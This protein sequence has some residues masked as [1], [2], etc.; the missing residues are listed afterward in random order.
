MGFFGWVVRTIG[1][2]IEK[3][4]DVVGS[5]VISSLGIA[6]QDACAGRL[7]SEK[8]YDKKEANIYTTDR[9]NEVLVSFSEG[10]LQQTTVIE[11]NCIRLVDEYYDKLI[12]IIENA[13]SDA[14]S[15]I[16]LR[17]LKSGKV[18]SAKTIIGSIKE[19]LSKRMSL[20]DSECLRILKMDSGSSKKQAMTEFTKKVIKEAV[21]NLSDNVRTALNELT[22]DIQDY[23]GGVSE[24]QEKATQA[25]KEQFDKMVRDNELEKS[26]KEKNC[27]LPLFLIDASKYVSQI[28]E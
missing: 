14:H 28:L 23:L 1:R 7:A 13:P 22:E 19:P 27:V 4:G 12:E 10:Y 20:D 18:K 8:S 16:N 5:D 21:N 17:A 6:I 9:L 11:K 24:E 26:E 25:F 15:A 3:M 2:G